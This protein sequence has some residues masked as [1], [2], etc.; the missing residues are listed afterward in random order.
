MDTRDRDSRDE[1]RAAVFPS[2]MTISPKSDI[3]E[4]TWLTFA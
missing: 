3:F 4:K 1:D 2:T